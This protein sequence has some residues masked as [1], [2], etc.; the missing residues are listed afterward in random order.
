MSSS[1]V[2]VN[3]A[4]GVRIRELTISARADASEKVTCQKYPSVSEENPGLS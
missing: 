3:R 2:A 4:T 1:S